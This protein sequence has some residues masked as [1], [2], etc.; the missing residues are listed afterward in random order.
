MLTSR[1]EKFLHGEFER[2]RNRALEDSSTF[3]ATG[4][5]SLDD[6]EVGAEGGGINDPDTYKINSSPV[7]RETP[8][9]GDA[10]DIRKLPGRD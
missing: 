10:V 3:E 8:A 9:K 7:D 1:T 4:L 2:Q 6:L 5:Y